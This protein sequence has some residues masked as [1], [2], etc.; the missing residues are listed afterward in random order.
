MRTRIPLPQLHN[1]AF[2]DALDYF[3]KI[4]Q[5]KQ[6][7]PLIEAQTEEAKAK[8]LKAKM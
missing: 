5:R 6:N 1:E 4:Q 8:A 7:K 3:E 2:S